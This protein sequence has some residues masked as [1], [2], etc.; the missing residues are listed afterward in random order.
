[1]VI[2]SR[3]KTENNDSSKFCCQCGNDLTIN[4]DAP[5]NED[6]KSLADSLNEQAVHTEKQPF[7]LNKALSEFPKKIWG[8]LKKSIFFRKKKNT[9]ITFSTVL[10][11]AL[12]VF[13]IFNSGYI[14]FTA[15]YNMGKYDAAKSIQGWSFNSNGV[16]SNME[17]FVISKTE[18]YYDDFSAEKIT[19]EEANE[20]FDIAKDFTSNKDAKNKADK[21]Q[22]S[23]NAYAKAE[24][25]EKSG[26]TF[27][28]VMEYLKVIEEDKNYN[29]AKEKIDKN[30]PS[31]KQQAIARMDD[32]AAVNDFNTGLKI[33]SD[34]EKIFTNDSDI[35]NYKKDFEDRKEAHRIQELKD[36][37]KVKVL[38]ASAFNDGYYII[39]RKGRVVL[40]NCNDKVLKEATVVF[41]TFDNNGYPVD[42]EYSMYTD[43]GVENTNRCGT[44]S[45][46]LHPGDTWGYGYSWSIADN[47]TKVKACVKTAEFYDGGTWTNPY[48]EHW[49]ETE[50]DR[51]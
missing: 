26:D 49:L 33:V 40:Q 41:L 47:A 37:Q 36:N 20:K 17:K 2:C 31:V 46:N 21:L 39:F 50:K 43:G 34:M 19:Y 9:I 8:W 48:Y 22:T 18:S 3:C 7:N 1:M 23:R 45:I 51:Y 38:S 10:L 25:Y 6:L 16:K 15:A 27:N 24:E 29:I 13:G 14:A 35:N 32:C 12:L 42:A 4:V 5:A 30:K 44:D 11:I 28:A